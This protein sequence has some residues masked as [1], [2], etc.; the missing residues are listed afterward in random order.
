LPDISNQAS[1][2]D[3]LQQ[4]R[5]IS[6]AAVRNRAPILDALRDV[7]PSSGSV[8]EVASGSGEHAVYMAQNL[9]EIIWTPSD[10]DAG[11]RAG[12]SAWLAK[13]ALENL[14]PLLDLATTDPDWAA[15]ALSALGQSPQALVCINM[16]HIAPWPACEGLFDGAQNLLET[17]GRLIL[18]GPF[19]EG[20]VL[21]PTNE[22]FDLWLKEHD[23]NWGVRALEDVC[24]AAAERGFDLLKTI[25]MPANN[26]TV[27]FVREADTR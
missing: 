20:G 7:L 24:L 18:Y 13:H 19:A 3:K 8:L 4:V 25:P 17:G 26:T 27:V 23:P 9:P 5:R 6:P 2:D 1:T 10:P 12:V 21:A 22:A 16:I 11:A 14:R 15:K